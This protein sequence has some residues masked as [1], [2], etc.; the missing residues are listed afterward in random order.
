MVNNLADIGIKKVGISIDS[1]DENIHDIHDS[2][3]GINATIELK[4]PRCGNINKI[5]LSLRRGRVKYRRITVG[6][7]LNN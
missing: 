3:F 2:S 5:D 1:S 7:Q 4:C 6:K